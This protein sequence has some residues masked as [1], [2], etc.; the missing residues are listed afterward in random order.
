MSNKLLTGFYSK[1]AEFIFDRLIR[2]W[3]G[4]CQNRPSPETIEG[5]TFQNLKIVREPNGEIALQLTNDPYHMSE[6]SKIKTDRRRG[7]SWSY[8]YI[9]RSYFDKGHSNPELASWIACRIKQ[10]VYKYLAYALHDTDLELWSRDNAA[11]VEWFRLKDYICK[12]D[13]PGLDDSTTKLPT[14]TELMYMYDSLGGHKKRCE[15]KQYNKK[16]IAELVGEEADPFMTEMEVNR[17]KELADLKAEENRIS[18]EIYD[19]YKEKIRELTKTLENE[20]DVKQAKLKA[21]YNEKRET[22]EAQYTELRNVALAA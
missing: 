20:R 6:Y 16:M 18:S 2:G 11:E 14:I 12:E 7:G 1:R 19:E 5:C 3:G 8:G 9:W 15:S 21:E 22:L 13:F 4:Q 10:Y 17:R